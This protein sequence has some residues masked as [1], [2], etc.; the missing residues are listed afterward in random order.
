M[1]GG[2]EGKKGG[3]EEQETGEE[4]G[5]RKGKETMEVRG[6]KGSQLLSLMPLSLFFFFFRF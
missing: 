1:R 2:T 3:M 5:E 4:R 6:G